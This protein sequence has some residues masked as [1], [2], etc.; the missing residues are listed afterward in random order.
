MATHAQGGRDTQTM[1]DM[2]QDW[3]QEQGLNFDH[4][5]VRHNLQHVLPGGRKRNSQS[6]FQR[7]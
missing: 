4:P 7:R 1:Q 3:A 5:S 6:T 2:F